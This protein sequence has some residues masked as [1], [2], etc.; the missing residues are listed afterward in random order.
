MNKLTSIIPAKDKWL[1]IVWQVNDFCNF[2][3]S[4]CNEGN[5]GGRFRHEDDL[6]KILVTLEHIIDLYQARGYR[7][8]KLFLSGGEPTL[9][10][11]LIPTVE[12]FR[13]KV[14]WPGSCVGINTNLSRKVSWW[15]KHHNLFEDVVASYHA[16]FTNADTY[17][18][19][20]KF[21]QDKS[22][23]LCAR[24]MMHK[25]K[26][27]QCMAITRR[28]QQECDNYIIDYVPVLDELRPTTEPYDYDEQW[29]VDFFESG[30]DLHVINKPI[31]ENYP[32]FA[33]ARMIVD[34]E[35]KPIDSNWIMQTRQ[36]YWKGW[37]CNIQDSLHI[38]PSGVIQ[39]A[40]C[41]VGPIV[42]SMTGEF[43]SSK[44]S[45]VICPKEYCHCSADFNIAKGPV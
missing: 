39:Q 20:Y 6:D 44:I 45:P 13:S 23:Y 26:W 12:L 40:S 9:W 7:Y 8:F 4:Y 21:L 34:G 17:V 30:P 16:E 24:V 29:Q 42:G 10:P 43:D 32:N 2:R 38:Y 1:S 11:G 27:D 36:N 25:T 3:C 41:G 15:E 28:L 35:N 18:E 31:K 33:Y 5:W 37:K 14:E 19:N 22:H